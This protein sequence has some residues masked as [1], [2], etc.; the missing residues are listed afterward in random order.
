MPPQSVIENALFRRDR[1]RETGEVTRY[2][3]RSITPGFNLYDSLEKL[4]CRSCTAVGRRLLQSV[5]DWTPRR[6]G[7][8]VK[9]HAD[10]TPGRAPLHSLNQFLNWPA[11]HD[12]ALRLLAGDDAPDHVPG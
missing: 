12:W 7:W 6:V 2:F 4:G 5:I 8:P 9:E 10:E 11:L 3:S 1:H